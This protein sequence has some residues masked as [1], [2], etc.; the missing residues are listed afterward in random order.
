[1]KSDADLL[2]LNCFFFIYSS[3][4]NILHF[5]SLNM[6]KYHLSKSKRSSPSEVMS[7]RCQSQVFVD[8]VELSWNSAKSGLG[9]KSCDSH[10][11]HCVSVCIA[12][13]C[14]YILYLQELIHMFHPRPVDVAVILLS[15]SCRDVRK[16]A[17]VPSRCLFSSKSGWIHVWTWTG[18]HFP[19]K[20]PVCHL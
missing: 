7:H 16:A 12:L 18:A 11:Q 9:S 14:M 10:P 3:L 6:Q 13:Y 4:L 19:K 5:Y 17:S 2:K 8:Y 20:G 15:R 1:M